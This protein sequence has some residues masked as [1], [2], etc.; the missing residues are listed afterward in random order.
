M[1]LLSERLILREF[2]EGDKHN[3]YKLFTEKYV[4]TY[5]EHLQIKHITDVENYLA[6]H[7]NNT[8][9][10][11]RTHFYYAIELQK[12]REFIGIIGYTFVEKL[13]HNDIVGY[14]AELEYYL[15]EEHQGSGYMPEALKRIFSHAFASKNIIKLFAQC[16]KSNVNSEKVMIKCGMYKS[17]SQ[18]K[19]KSSYGVLE[20]RVRY[21]M[22]VDEYKRG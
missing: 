11:D 8:N 12:T 13:K 17:A 9:S 20:E 18:P 15:L 2:A 7:I 5:E 14:V 6:F 16:R 1:E 21:E 10:G 3:L 4:Q 22:T 19:P